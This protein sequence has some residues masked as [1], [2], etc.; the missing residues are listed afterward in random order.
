MRNNIVWVE[1]WIDGA[2]LD[3]IVL[4]RKLR[5][6]RFE[7]ITA[8]HPVKTLEWFE[9][10]EEACNWLSEEEFDLVEGRYD[11]DCEFWSRTHQNG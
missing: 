5:D 10:Y 9:S 8:C 11:Q 7:L 6:E 2:S 1:T 4:L 3:G